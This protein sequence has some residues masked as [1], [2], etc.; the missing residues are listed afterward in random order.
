VA[1]AGRAAK[2]DPAALSGK[3]GSLHLRPDFEA[4]VSQFARQPDA[5]YASQGELMLWIWA[6]KN[7]RLEVGEKSA[8]KVM[9]KV[10]RPWLHPWLAER[11]P[12]TLKV[13]AVVEKVV[14][15]GKEI[16]VKEGLVEIEWGGER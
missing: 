1:A 3:P 12:L 8:A 9:V 6:R 2:K 7:V 11:C 10:T 15:R 4:W 14:W 13:P 5:W 16:A